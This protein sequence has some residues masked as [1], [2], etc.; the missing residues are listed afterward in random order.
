VI[1]EYAADC[2]RKMQPMSVYN[3]ERTPLGL[4]EKDTKRKFEYLRNLRARIT[5]DNLGTDY[6]SLAYLKRERN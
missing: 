3:S 2:P 5:F 6:S 4:S 1:A